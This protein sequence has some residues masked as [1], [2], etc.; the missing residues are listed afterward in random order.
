MYLTQTYL[1]LSLCIEFPFM[2]PICE[3]NTFHPDNLDYHHWE[4]VQTYTT[5]ECQLNAAWHLERIQER[6]PNYIQSAP[7]QK[8][9]STL[10]YVIDTWVD[11]DHPN[12]QNRVFRGPSFAT[13]QNGHGTHVAGLITSANFGVQKNASVCS[14]QVL[15]GNGAGSTTQVLQGMSAAYQDWI[16]RKK[17]KALISM[18]IGGGTSPLLNEAVNSLWF[19]GLPSIVAAG[20]SHVD[21]CFAS[22][23]GAQHAITIGATDKNDQFAGFSNY[24]PCVTLNAPGVDI[25][26]L[27]PNNLE[28]MMSGTSMATPIVSG[29]AASMNW[30]SVDDLK[31]QLLS[32]STKQFIHQIPNNTVNLLAFA[33][34]PEICLKPNPPFAI[35]N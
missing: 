6:V 19:A 8:P 33:F 1:N 4:Y 16:A 14:I 35:Q 26:S 9:T 7:I 12:F 32:L 13:G 17:P 18:S 2:T 31:M 28:A 23:S 10:V 22:P 29:I 34:P 20:N 15:D 24:G 3:V 21:A 27:Y 11:I 5:Q 25:H 30:N